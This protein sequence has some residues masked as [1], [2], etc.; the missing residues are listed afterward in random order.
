MKKLLSFVLTLSFAV[1][2]FSAVEVFTLSSGEVFTG[3][4]EGEKDGKIVFR[5]QYGVLNIPSSSVAKKELA[6]VDQ[7]IE[8]KIAKDEKDAAVVAEEAKPVAK[9]VDPAAP[10]PIDRDPQWVED[11]RNF[12]E[13]YFPEGWQF[14]L[15]GGL[16][17]KD[18]DSSTFSFNVSF[19]VKK[20][21]DINVFTATAYYN[22]T[23]QT[24]SAGNKD[25]TIDN[26]GL[27]T[28]FKRFFNETKTWYIANILNYKRDQV[29]DIEH[30][31]DEAITFGYRFDFKRHNLVIDVGPGPAVRYIDSSVQGVDWVVMALIQED[32]TWGISRTFSFEQSLGATWDLEETDQYSVT[33]KMALI[34]HLTK[35][36]DLAIRYSYQYDNI[37]SLTVT[38]EQRLII[39][40]EFPFNWQ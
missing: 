29:K 37:S 39:A 31:V 36:M 28:T 12:V 32:L 5:T 4:S 9:P 35:V 23:S 27:D 19:D 6:N 34:A 40:F 14:R 2:A 38:T 3:V 18:T 13:H 11:Y 33:F 30:Q 21:W 17:F 24:D 25:V 22:Y 20:E 1:S 15:R 16:E 8:A 7:S 26:Y 10:D